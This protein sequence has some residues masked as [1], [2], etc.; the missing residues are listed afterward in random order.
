MRAI[1]RIIHTRAQRPTLIVSKPWSSW[2][3]TRLSTALEL[4]GA[5]KQALYTGYN[6]I[7]RNYYTT[8]YYKTSRSVRGDIFGYETETPDVVVVMYASH[9]ISSSFQ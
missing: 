4:F 3:L 1:Q 6:K 2:R 5:W 7:V 9:A 8:Q